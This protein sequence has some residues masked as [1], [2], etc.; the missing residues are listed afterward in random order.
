MT[1]RI[2]D[3]GDDGKADVRMAMAKQH[4]AVVRGKIVRCGDCK[5]GYKDVCERPIWD[6]GDR[7][8]TPIESGGY[9]AWGER[10]EVRDD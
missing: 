5:H 6:D 1:E 2:V 7:A 4:G 9:C 8:C 3:F 10:R